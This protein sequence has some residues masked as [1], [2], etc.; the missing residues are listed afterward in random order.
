MAQSPSSPPTQPTY[1]IE[2]HINLILRVKELSFPWEMHHTV[3]PGTIGIYCCK[4]RLRDAE[5]RPNLYPPG[6]TIKF[7][8]FAAAPWSDAMQ[9]AII[10]SQGAQRVKVTLRYPL[11]GLAGEPATLA[12][13]VRFEVTDPIKLIERTPGW[14]RP[15]GL[16]RLNEAVARDIC[17]AVESVVRP[18][19][20]SLAADPALLTPGGSE[21]LQ[22]RIVAGTNLAERGL[23]LLS[24]QPPQASLE[25]PPNLLAALYDLYTGYV[26]WQRRLATTPEAEREALANQLGVEDAEVHARLLAGSAPPLEYLVRR[27]PDL[28]GTLAAGRAG[29]EPE[30]AQVLRSLLVDPASSDFYGE[31]AAGLLRELRAPTPLTRTAIEALASQ[32]RG[33]R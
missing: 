6:T 5:G 13:V 26:I 9:H 32:S 22:E 23:S 11:P 18:L 8:L 15:G 10:V 1:E 12:T 20:H 17:D 21:R 27:R 2:H 14:E 31:L 33:E 16:S 24:D 29:P 19:T 25:Y 7:Q 3:L 28:L 4:G 30:P